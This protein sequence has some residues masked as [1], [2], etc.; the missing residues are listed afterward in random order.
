MP[1]STRSRKGLGEFWETLT[2]PRLGRAPPVFP[3][4]LEN[5]A[6][7]C[8]CHFGLAPPSSPLPSPRPDPAEKHVWHA[9]L[10]TSDTLRILK[11]LKTDGISQEEW[12]GRAFPGDLGLGG[13]PPPSRLGEQLL[14]G[15]MWVA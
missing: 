12:V 1:Q 15:S 13:D 5:T 10:Q 8:S 3:S 4:Y 2:C 7:I 9:S 6:Q 14:E 11:C